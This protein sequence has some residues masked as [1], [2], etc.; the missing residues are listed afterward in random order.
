M[1]QFFDS[2]ERFYISAG[3]TLGIISTYIVSFLK[4]IFYDYLNWQYSLIIISFIVSSLVPRFFRMRKQVG[5]L[6]DI[7]KAMSPAL[8]S[9]D[10]KPMFKLL[11]TFGDLL[12]NTNPHQI[13]TNPPQN[14]ADSF[15]IDGSLSPSDSIKEGK[16]TNEIRDPESICACYSI[17]DKEHEI[18]VPFVPSLRR[19]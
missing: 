3:F 12:S 19:A 5:A 15:G 2:K 1:E 9:T 14:N 11:E 16:M 17:D 18:N 8:R 7:Y 10:A 13:N 6:F 4:F